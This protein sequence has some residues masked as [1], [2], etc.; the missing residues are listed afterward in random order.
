MKIKY[1]LKIAW[2]GISTHKFRSFLTVLG[3]VI[4]VTSIML[5]MALGGEAQNVIIK[6]IQGMGSKTIVVLPGREPSGPS[7]FAQLFSDSLKKR[8][9]EELLK[10]ENAPTID[11]VIP[12]V[13]GSEVS[14]YQGDTYRLTI[15]GSSELIANIFDIYPEKGRFFN[16]EEV[17]SSANV[18]VIGD[19][20][21]EE[22]FG[23]SFDVI[24]ERIKIKG[25]NFVIVGI[26]PKRGQVSFF[27]FDETALIPY[28]T[29][30]QYIFGIK[31]FNRLIIE[32]TSEKD[33]QQTVNDIKRILREN[34]NIT[35]PE[36]DDFYVQTSVDIE[37]RLKTV[38]GVLTIFLT[39]VAA[40]S[41]LVGGIGIMNIMLVAVTERTKEIGLRKAL[42]A[43]EKDIMQQFLFESLILTTLGGIIGIILGG[44][45]TFLSSIIL[46]KVVGFGWSFTFPFS[47]ALLGISVSALVGIV[48]GLYPARQ[49][50]LKNPIDA[51][52]YE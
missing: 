13:F 8:D 25:K 47:A 5:I 39:A 26:L 29:A 18:V 6:Q 41:L 49:A 40:I 31:H 17:K 12:I 43:K 22:F 4:G 46:S 37:S 27:N 38:T 30:Q 50:S 48:F 45:L 10:K 52:R 51:L 24:G 19:K 20:V 33:I 9:L 11:K 35:D 28:T 44:S 15:F 21:R 2:S 36:K 42:G 34:H 14:S 7:G 3:I 16:E 32:S 1:V 23:Q